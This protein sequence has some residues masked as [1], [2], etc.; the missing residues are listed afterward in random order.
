[1]NRTVGLKLCDLEKHRFFE[2]RF[3]G[4]KKP[5]EGSIASSMHHPNIVETLEYG[6]TN[7]D[8]PYL[9][10]EFVEGPGLQLL[11]HNRESE[12]LAGKRLLIDQADGRRAALCS[13]ARLYPSRHLPSQLYLLARYQPHQADR[14]W[15]DG[16]RD[17]SLYAARQPNRHAAL[18]GPR[19]RSSP[20]D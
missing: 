1:M 9:V 5:S 11:I 10:M 17:A 19:S 18:H 2:S 3:K 6:L 8:E 14:L 4:M 13:Q 16:S 7:K 12:M 15:I 20:T